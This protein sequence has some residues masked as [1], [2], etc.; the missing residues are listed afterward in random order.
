[1]ADRNRRGEAIGAGITLWDTFV[2]AVAEEPNG[3]ITFEY[4]QEFLERGWEISPIHLNRRV[5]GRNPVSFPELTKMEAFAGLPGVLADALPDR[6][7]NAIIKKYFSDRGQPELALSPVQRL[8]YL[9]NRAMGALQFAPAVRRESNRAEEL[10]LQLSRLVEQA[11]AV[12]EGKIDVAIPEIMRVGTSA[13]GARPKAIILWHPGRNTVRSDFAQ[14]NEGE[15][16]WIIK[17]DGVGIDGAPDEKTKPYNRIEKTYIDIAKR[18]GIHTPQTR[19][20]VERGL[21]HLMSKRFDRD[22]QRRLHQHTLGGLQHLDYD[23]PG[24]YSYEGF[25]RTILALDTREPYPMLQE[26]FRRAVFNVALVNQDDHVKNISFV[27]DP[28]PHGGWQLAPA[29]D[30]TF[31]FGAGFTKQHQM[32]VNGKVEKITRADLLAL[33]KFAGLRS[34]GA[35]EIDAVLDARSHWAAMAAKAKVPAE[36]VAAIEKKFPELA[37]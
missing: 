23:S 13:G 12:I 14:P 5:I 36:R 11:R 21:A 10:P 19:L 15:E 29:Y 16:H 8:L 31:A 17:F 9:G 32:S 7:G 2:G 22:G 25:M 1:M 24:D 33:G 6:F 3:R 26:A 28:K 18:A 35:E 30:L 27:M 20:L 34:S 37:G 4:S